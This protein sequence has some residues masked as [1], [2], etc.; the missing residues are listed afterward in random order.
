MVDVP[1]LLPELVIGDP[2][3]LVRFGPTTFSAPYETLPTALP[4]GVKSSSLAERWRDFNP[5]PGGPPVRTLRGSKARSVDCQGSGSRMKL[6]K[7]AWTRRP[8]ST[9]P[10][11]PLSTQ[12]LISVS[13][14]WGASA[15]NRTRRLSFNRTSIIRP[16]LEAVAS[17]RFG[18]FWPRNPAAPD[19]T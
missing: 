17:K 9:K 8:R 2:G 18:L 4:A 6:S 1:A 10:T 19:F 5:A 12:S 13:P 16:L 11:D 7:R 15:V 3:D 14:G